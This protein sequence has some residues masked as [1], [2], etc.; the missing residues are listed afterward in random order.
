[1]AHDSPLRIV[2]NLPSTVESVDTVQPLTVGPVNGRALAQAKSLSFVPLRRV[3]MAL[4]QTAV[5]VGSVA[6]TQISSQQAD[7]QPTSRSVAAPRIST[8]HGRTAVIVVQTANK[9]ISSQQA[10]QPATKQISGRTT[11][12]RHLCTQAPF[13]GCRIAGGAC[14]RLPQVAG[15]QLSIQLEIRLK[16]GGKLL[17]H[18]RN[19]KNIF[20]PPR[21]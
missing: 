16:F 11:N 4:V 12:P 17:I 9:Q 2:P 18:N 6:N 3:R 13:A 15:I 7:Q 20:F 19:P 1:M 14:R 10:D 8:A 5:I 21:L